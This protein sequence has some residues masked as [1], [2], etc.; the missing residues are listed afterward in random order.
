MTSS[1][2]TRSADSARD[3]ATTAHRREPDHRRAGRAA[4][5]SPAP[6]EP[7]TAGN[8]ADRIER[9]G[10]RRSA[11]A[12]TAG[13]SRRA[14]AARTPPAPVT[15]A[16]GVPATVAPSRNRCR[17]QPR[18]APPHRLRAAATAETGQPRR[19]LRRPRP[20]AG[21]APTP[22]APR[23]NAA[24]G[25]PAKRAPPHRRNDAV[26]TGAAQGA[27]GPRWHPRP[28]GPRRNLGPA[29]HRSAGARE[30]GAAAEADDG[31]RS[32]TE[33]GGSPSPSCW[34]VCR[35]ARPPKVAGGA[36][37]RTEL[38]ACCVPDRPVPACSGPDRNE[39]TD[40]S[41]VV[42]VGTP[43]GLR[44]ARLKVGIISAGRVG[45]A[46][47]VALERAEHVVV[48][49]SAVSAASRQRAQRRL[50]DTPIL[51]VHEVADR[52]ELLLLAVPDAELAALVTGLAATSSVTGHD[53]RAHLGRQRHRRARAADRAGLRPAGD[54][55]GDDV[56][57]RRRGHRPAVGHAA[58]GSPPPTRS[59]TR[60]RSRWCWRSAAS[61]SGS[62]RMPAR[63]TTRRWPTRSNHVVTVV[64]DAVDAL[65]A[66]L[67]G[68]GTARPATGGRRARRPRRAGASA[69][70]PGRRWTTP[71]SGARLR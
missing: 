71:C 66:A 20:R 55:S 31:R 70:W 53:R 13:P 33:P 42:C 34:P 19:R 24:A 18:T 56:H 54:P 38:P 49:C 22:G 1:R 41:E 65:R 39:S 15:A 5:R 8:T 10:D 59:A 46:L 62:A 11:A 45:T 43:D 32:R 16:A 30:A 12:A 35:P 44:P 52:S 47:G 64:A 51:P 69:R 36:D 6:A 60:S 48:A 40:V 2:I 63:S 4:G 23:R 7:I 25:T 37:A 14:G 27:A 50:P 61:R 57:R 9:P 68:P 58:S 26:G 17:P 67:S 21:A 3:D 28:A 29:T